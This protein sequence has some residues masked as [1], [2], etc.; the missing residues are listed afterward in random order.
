MATGRLAH[1]SDDGCREQ[2]PGKNIVASGR[3]TH[4]ACSRAVAALRRPPAVS[5]AANL[6]PPATAAVNCQPRC[7]LTRW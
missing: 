2:I 6:L 3:P 7:G 1:T 4:A 5:L